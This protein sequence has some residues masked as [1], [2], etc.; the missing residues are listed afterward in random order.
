MFNKKPEIG[1]KIVKRYK[2]IVDEYNSRNLRWLWSKHKLDQL[3]KDEFEGHKGKWVTLEGG[4]HIFIRE[5]ESLQEALG[6]LSEKPKEEFG[7]N[8]HPTF[9][10]DVKYD[11]KRIVG[12]AP[13]EHL[14]GLKEVSV[15]REIGTYKFDEREGNISGMYFK[16]TISLH[17]GIFHTEDRARKVILHEVGHHVYSNKL[18]GKKK[19]W[20]T[21]W[22]E[23]KNIMP[24]DYSKSNSNEGFAECYSMYQNDW[25]M[26]KEKDIEDWF[27]KNIK[28]G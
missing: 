15:V 19:E 8:I 26:S 23:N 2:L 12:Y 11:A 22:S 13:K 21:F 16:D 1:D 18:D 3:I 25:L 10:D 5:G 28:K 4:Q 7:L 24:N 9:S 27:K 20:D 6:R 14:E 17:G